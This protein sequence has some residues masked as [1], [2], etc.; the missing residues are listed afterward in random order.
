MRKINKLLITFAVVFANI[1]VYAAN[2]TSIKSAAVT[3]GQGSNSSSTVIELKG[4]TIEGSGD[5][6][7]VRLSLVDKD[8][9][10][11]AGTD[12]L[13]FYNTKFSSGGNLYFYNTK[14]GN[15]YEVMK[16]NSVNWNT[17]TGGNCT[18]AKV[19]TSLKF[20]YDSKNEI[21][22]SSANISDDTFFA[23]I[24]SFLEKLRDKVNE[25]WEKNEDDTL[26]QNIMKKFGI[27]DPTTRDLLLEEGIY[28][29]A[30]PIGTY[31]FGTDYFVTDEEYSAYLNVIYP[32]LT[33][34]SWEEPSNPYYVIKNFNASTGAQLANDFA[35]TLKNYSNYSGCTLITQEL[36]S[37]RNS[38]CYKNNNSAAVK[39]AC[40]KANLEGLN[41]LEKL[42]DWGVNSN[43][44]K[45]VASA[46]LASIK[47]YFNNNKFKFQSVCKGDIPK[48]AYANA[49][50]TT[51]DM[52]KAAKFYFVG[53]P[54]ELYKFSNSK[55]WESGDVKT[56]LISYCK[57]K[58]SIKGDCDNYISK[59]N[60]FN[61]YYPECSSCRAFK[62]LYM[63]A[64]LGDLVYTAC[65][66]HSSSTSG[67]GIN[68][69]SIL[70]DQDLKDKKNC[71]KYFKEIEELV[72][73]P[74]NVVKEKLSSPIDV[75]DING[76]KVKG[77]TLEYCCDIANYP[78]K[79]SKDANN[80]IRFTG[81]DGDIYKVCHQ[82]NA[83]GID[84]YNKIY[85][86]KDKSV[87]LIKDVLGSATEITDEN[88]N[89]VNLDYCCKWDNYSDEFKND[90]TN[91]T[92]IKPMFNEA[93][94][95]AASGEI[96][97]ICNLQPE[98][99]VEELKQILKLDKWGDDPSK[100]ANRIDEIDTEIKNDHVYNPKLYHCCN[101]EN[102]SDTEL[103]KINEI[104]GTKDKNKI[105]TKTDFNK[106][107]QK[108]C[109]YE[110]PLCAQEQYDLLT[111]VS[112]GARTLDSKTKISTWFETTIKYC[113]DFDFEKLPLW[114]SEAVQKIGKHNVQEIIN[115]ACN[116]TDK[117]TYEKTLAKGITE[118]TNELT[119]ETLNCCEFENIDKNTLP[120][121]SKTTLQEFQQLT[122]YKKYCPSNACSYNVAK[123]KIVL[124][125]EMIQA[126]KTE[127]YCCD[128]NNGQWASESDFITFKNDKEIY[129]SI[130]PKQ[131]ACEYKGKDTKKTQIVNDEEVDC[132]DPY[133]YDR[134][135][136]IKDL[137]KIEKPA[138]TVTKSNYISVFKST[139]FYTEKCMNCSISDIT[140][141]NTECCDINKYSEEDQRNYLTGSSFDR[142]KDFENYL[143]KNY[144]EKYKYCKPN[145]PCDYEV[146]SECPNCNT[147]LTSTGYSY[148]RINGKDSTLLDS[149]E[150]TSDDKKC[151]V[152]NDT[153][154][155]T[156]Y[157][158]GDKNNLA[159]DSIGN[160]YC[161]VYC[162]EKVVY[163]YPPGLGEV[164]AGRIYNFGN[165]RITTVK[166]CRIN[167]ID[168]D[169]FVADLSKA[170]D[171]LLDAYN[172]YLEYALALDGN[173]AKYQAPKLACE[174]VSGTH[175]I[176]VPYQKG[177]KVGD[178]ENPCGCRYS[179]NYSKTGS[180][181]CCT[182]GGTIQVKR[183]EYTPDTTLSYRQDNGCLKGDVLAGGKCQGG[184]QSQDVPGTKKTLID[185]ARC[186]YAYC[187]TENDDKWDYQYVEKFTYS[188]LA[189][190]T[191]AHEKGK[192]CKTTNSNKSLYS[193]TYDN[194]A[195]SMWESV[196]N[197]Y[198]QYKQIIENYKSCF[199][200]TG[201]MQEI[202]L[203]YDFQIDLEYQQG[204]YSHSETLEKKLTNSRVYE[205]ANTR[206]RKKIEIPNTKLIVIDENRDMSTQGPVV[207]QNAYSGNM[208]KTIY[209]ISLGREYTYTMTSG[210]ITVNKGIPES[211]EEKIKEGLQ[212]LDIGPHLPVSY[213]MTEDGSLELITSIA[214]RDSVE[215]RTDLPLCTN[216][217]SESNNYYCPFSVYDKLILELGGVLPVYRP[218]ILSNPFPDKDGKGRN[219]GVNWCSDDDC[220]NTNAVVRDVIT[221][222]RGVTEEN[223]YNLRPLYTINLTP[224]VIQNIR[225][226][227]NSTNYSDFNLVCS[228][229]ANGRSTGRNCESIFLRGST[230]IGY[231]LENP[232]YNLHDSQ[233][234]VIDLN[235]SCALNQ[236]LSNCAHDDYFS[237]R[238]GNS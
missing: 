70:A 163:D 63:N 143:K 19:A 142:Q 37:D 136:L 105:I 175:I 106:L 221:Y 122:N 127:E 200:I 74:L 183:N 173:A 76:N 194:T 89:I 88:G 168:T 20:K 81:P 66:S 160:K 13:D 1:N 159:S 134:D 92:K 208:E 161:E 181:S 97:K 156:K 169:A 102:Y 166:T 27:T 52:S 56:E 38:K 228:L 65:S 110:T 99:T 214:N 85:S 204:R 211:V 177:D 202:L 167:G 101:V 212:Q 42:S 149:E 71:T 17:C 9:K 193:C 3:G 104:Y 123:R 196:S 236:S 222:N 84:E 98:C 67:C 91:K 11:L 4:G 53:T 170:R 172:A 154:K 141:K 2:W 189:G 231:D 23:D 121:G 113:C 128:N 135:Q 95:Y 87:S 147:T 140:E 182:N 68:A 61:S 207:I 34:C 153:Y 60:Q 187:T 229:D 51:T 184:C 203:D 190:N 220:S 125:D 18:N 178:K 83:C 188:S 78:S 35:K 14:Q 133:N 6:V 146:K 171:K 234:G 58:A 117:C 223:V 210:Y 162:T 54:S 112:N 201:R 48:A 46:Y 25:Q 235:N 120:G 124:S 198:G 64:K 86:L 199:D 12:V 192:I 118:Y 96:Y 148:D 144:P 137:Q 218:I 22:F 209:S 213:D 205:D 94:T 233:R 152:Q 206:T 131:N 57:N 8:G 100:P 155:V 41:E 103:K 69:V 26:A 75:L 158:G 138:V 174:N 116:I 126:N 129:Y 44:T 191:T 180:I 237:A 151:I 225:R 227:N 77:A 49:T 72:N 186:I 16:S 32:F 226:Y 145:V 216:E 93:S 164:E 7:G 132:C 39:A 130:C 108:Q 55:A 107:V 139:D 115:Q 47:T 224:Q 40:E 24:K 157:I 109:F 28:L 50:Y 79:F 90:K 82:K 232:T 217:E 176:N 195:E 31:M 29:T 219:T 185:A 230:S 215:V 43:I 59:I 21:E 197:L 15:K 150:I 45:S 80:Q 73:K 36:C 165:P 119:G 238:G 111:D 179:Y 62:Y 33:N 5:F 114:D 10:R 30:E